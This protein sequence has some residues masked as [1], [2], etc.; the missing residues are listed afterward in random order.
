MSRFLV[1]PR[2]TSDIAFVFYVSMRLFVLSAAI[3]F[4]WRQQWETAFY[5]MLIALMMVAPS[6][7]KRQY[8][9]YLPFELDF[10]IVTFVFFTLFLGSLNNFYKI[11]P[12]WDKMAHF[13]SGILIGSLGFV[14]VYMLN[15]QKSDRLNL[16]PG[17]ISF[18]AFCF[19]LT[20]AVLWEIFEYTVDVVTGVSTMQGVGIDDT[21]GDFIVCTVGAFVIGTIGFVWMLWR[22]RVPFTPRLL[23]RMQY[24]GKPRRSQSLSRSVK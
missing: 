6:I 19:S 7:L 13:G 20:S 1:L 9:L 17:F 12:W 14:L 2:N 22:E 11:Y 4:L 5:T 10:S 24:S 8:Q 18:F 23:R 15:E 21:M 3:V 16:S